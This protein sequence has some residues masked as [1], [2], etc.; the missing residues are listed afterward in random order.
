MTPQQKEAMRQARRKAELEKGWSWLGERAPAERVVGVAKRKTMHVYQSV[1]F[2]SPYLTDN[3]SHEDEL[4]EEAEKPELLVP[5]TVEL[6]VDGYRIR[7]A[8][9]WNLNGTL[10]AISTLTSRIVAYA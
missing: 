3:G 8:F 7:D 10:A 9:L 2:V 1:S 4:A 5:I 6:V